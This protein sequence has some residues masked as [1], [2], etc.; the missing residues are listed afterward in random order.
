MSV[1][2]RVIHRRGKILFQEIW[3]CFHQKSESWDHLSRW[4]GDEVTD[5]DR[6]VSVYAAIFGINTICARTHCCA[7]CDVSEP[8]KCKLCHCNEDYQSSVPS[9]CVYCLQARQVI[10]LCI[11]V[12]AG[13]GDDY[14]WFIAKDRFKFGEKEPVRDI[15]LA[16]IVLNGDIIEEIGL[17]GFVDAVPH[18]PNCRYFALW[19]HQ[20][21]TDPDYAVTCGVEAY[22]EAAEEPGAEDEPS[23]E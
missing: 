22:P 2:Q 13:A 11:S 7:E 6:I 5:S 9:D 18:L 16:D 20:L 8:N 15:D 4:I 10:D 21:I 23:P 17:E 12:F 19:I 1:V 3:D 14:D